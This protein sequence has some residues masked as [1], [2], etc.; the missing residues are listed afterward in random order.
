MNKV[1]LFMIAAIVAVSSAFVSCEKDDP[2]PASI[3]FA[4]ASGDKVTLE[5]GATSYTA[6]AQ[7]SSIENLKSIK[8]SLKVGSTTNQIGNTITKFDSKT[9]HNLVVSITN[10]TEDCELTVT[11]ENG[12]ETSR[13]LKISYT[14][15]DPEPVFGDIKAYTAVLMGA[16]SATT[17]SSYATSNNTVYKV[18]EVLANANIIDMIYYYQD[19]GSGNLAEIFSPK[20]SNAGTL[21]TIKDMNPKRDTK[22]KKVTM[23]EA[24]FNAIE[25]DGKIVE[26][27]TGLTESVVTQLAIGNVVAFVTDDDRLGL[28]RVS[29]LATGASGSITI[30]VK[31]QK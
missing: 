5:K 19:G 23:T 28:F 3:S 31:V 10:I 30:N 9:S 14:A 1:S 18:T 26:V 2:D 13:T 16:Q 15:P 29:A 24:E 21:N 22:F 11:V 8:A 25:N 6:T 12:T 20:S 4:N 17:G 27:A 7:I